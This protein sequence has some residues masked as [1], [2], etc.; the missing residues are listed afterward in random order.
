MAAGCQEE[1]AALERPLLLVH[2]MPWYASKEQGGQWGWHWTMDHYDPDQLDPARG[3][4]LASHYEPLAGPYDSGDPLLID[5]HLQLMK[6]AGIDGV[7]IDWYGTSRSLDYPLLHRNTQRMIES[8]RSASMR[9]AICYEDQSLRQVQPGSPEEIQRQALLDLRWW[10]ETCMED[11]AHVR[12]DGKPVLLVFGPQQLSADLWKAWSDRLPMR[13]TLFGLPHLV[14]DRGMD[15]AY[16]WPPVSGSMEI[17][18]KV[19]GEYLDALDRDPESIGCIFPGFH[20]IYQQAGVHASYGSIDER[21]GRTFQETVERAL[22]SRRR[23][24][25]V[26]TWNDFGEGTMIEP[27]LQRQYRDLEVLRQRNIAGT[28]GSATD[29][30]LPLL[31]YQSRLVDRRSGSA[32]AEALNE[33]STHLLNGRY[34]EARERWQ[35][36]VG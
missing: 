19:W 9:Y 1:P 4:R 21:D 17:S 28:A 25:Q 20:D 23:L 2:Y 26:A 30:T 14:A 16:G 34:R 5:Y 10:E 32:K 12:V 33:V 31:V 35:A 27:T 11:P 13:P 18:P 6:I 36:L 7:V 29:L 8:I 24:L 3:G 22:R 15:H